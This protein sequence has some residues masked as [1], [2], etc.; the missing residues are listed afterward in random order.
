MKQ[1]KYCIWPQLSIFRSWIHRSKLTEQRFLHVLEL[2]QLLY[3][4]FFYLGSILDAVSM[5]KIGKRSMPEMPY[6]LFNVKAAGR[7]HQSME[8]HA[9]DLVHFAF[10]TCL[11]KQATR[12]NN[13]K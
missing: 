9:F 2:H 8:F 5:F 12:N 1:G 10:C 13:R 6:Y 11:R 3:F 4:I 7:F